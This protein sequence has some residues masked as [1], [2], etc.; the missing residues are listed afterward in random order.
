MINNSKLAWYLT[1]FCDAESFFN[2]TISPKQSGGYQVSLRFGITLHEKDLPLLNILQKYF[3]G[4]GTISVRK[5]KNCKNPIAYWS[6][7]K[8]D[9]I[10]NV[11]IPHFEKYSLLTQKQADFLLFKEIALLMNN[12]EHLTDAGLLKILAIKASMNLGLSD[13]LSVSF[14]EIIPN[15]R[16]VIN[17]LEIPDPNWIAGFTDGDGS[18]FVN[19]AKTNSKLGH[20]IKLM[21]RLAQHDRDLNLFNLIIKY[22]NCGTIQRKAYSGSQMHIIDLNIS[23]FNDIYTKIIP[24]FKE[25]KLKSNKYLDFIDFCE[26]ANIINDSQHLT[27]EGIAKIL[28]I[29]AKMNS[30]RI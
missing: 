22:F 29:K 21:F 16:P 10:Y 7:R 20:S 23:K 14:P 19:I 4:I 18:F 5:H 8:F 6:V 11:V 27:P 3:N 17:T 2:V 24:F 12:K 13:N 30:N 15:K 28:A 26:V 1:G 25:Y 9:D